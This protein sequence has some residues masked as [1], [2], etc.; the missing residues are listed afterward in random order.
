MCFSGSAVRLTS[1]GW[2]VGYHG[3]FQA[4]IT[5]KPV[6]EDTMAR[7]RLRLWI[8]GFLVAPLLSVHGQDKLL[9][10]LDQKIPMPNV[11]GRLDHFGVDVKGGRL[12]V[13]ALGDNQNTVEVI[14]LKNGKRVF[15]IPG[16]SKPQG[17]FYSAE[18]K[19]LFVANG[20]DGTC[21]I[22]D[23]DTFK[24]IDS[25]PIGTDADHVG[26]DPATKYLYVGFGDAKSGGLAIIDTRTNKH[27]ADVKTDARPGGIK[28][29]KSKSQTF[30]TLTG[31]TKLGVVDLKKREQT[32]TWPTE[33]AG[34]VALALDESDRRLFD[35][36]REPATLIVL[37]TESGKQVSQVEGV[38]G[39]DDLWYDAAHKRV[40]ASG[41]RGFDVGFI[42]TY[43]QKDADHYELIGKVPTAP[44]AGTSFWLPEL[45][46]L[47]V[48][49]PAN[50]KEEAA[51]L[52]FEPQP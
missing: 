6:L 20:T 33:V 39:I 21:K 47:Y 2:T 25:L 4:G 1:L 13:A 3:N 29:E 27:I 7:R 17:L 35:G 42:Y 9:L 51:V 32:S 50:D 24:L 48:G 31:A 26:Y 34:N 41:G 8:M 16:Q 14:D 40:Y 10:K 52:V 46:R 30:V 45:N 37:D 11:Q 23:G 38:A 5:G 43:Q 49:A 15:S 18:F 28:T 36:V 12:F 44:G 22:F 19:K